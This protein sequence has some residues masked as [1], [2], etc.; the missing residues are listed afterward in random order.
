MRSKV[1]YSLI[2][3]RTSLPDPMLGCAENI[4]HRNVFGS[5][6][7]CSLVVIRMLSGTLWKLIWGAFWKPWKHF[8]GFEGSWGQV[9]IWMDFRT[10]PAYMVFTRQN[11]PATGFERPIFSSNHVPRMKHTDLGSHSPRSRAQMNPASSPKSHPGITT[12]RN[13]GPK[14]TFKSIQTKPLLIYKKKYSR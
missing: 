9:R 1:D 3:E 11:L 12:H 4:I 10:L 14:P 7:F 2:W 13:K 6:H 5:F 8:G